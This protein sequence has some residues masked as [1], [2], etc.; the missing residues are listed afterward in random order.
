MWLCYAL[1]FYIFYY[2]VFQINI[3][4]LRKKGNGDVPFIYILDQGKIKCNLYT[5]FVRLL[6]SEI[7]FSL[8]LYWHIV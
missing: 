2:I 8:N 5:N 1:I 7:R 3:I 4:I 6:V